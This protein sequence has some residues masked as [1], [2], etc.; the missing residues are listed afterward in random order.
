MEARRTYSIALQRCV[1]LCY[2][3][4][5]KIICGLARL[6][7]LIIQ[8]IYSRPVA[9]ISVP[10]SVVSR[11]NTL[12]H[13]HRPIDGFHHGYDVRHVSWNA[14]TTMIPPNRT[15]LYDV[16]DVYKPCPS[17]VLPPVHPRTTPA[18]QARLKYI[19]K[20]FIRFYA[21]FLYAMS[22]RRRRR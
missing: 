17:R 18:D 6:R 10:S 21:S 11:R 8:P 22:T 20:I 16:L 12:T 9:N 1:S 13:Q 3:L 19:D 14:A 2:S 15:F 5:L 4:F 7:Y